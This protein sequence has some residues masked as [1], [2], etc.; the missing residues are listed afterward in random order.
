MASAILMSVRGS[1]RDIAKQWC[2]T[3][4]GKSAPRRD[5]RLRWLRN[6]GKTQARTYAKW[7][8]RAKVAEAMLNAFPALEK[9]ENIATSGPIFSS[10]R[11]RLSS[12]PC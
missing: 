3:S 7:P 8:R 10:S 11:P 6:I 9:L 4:F 12:A 2:I 1:R 5:G